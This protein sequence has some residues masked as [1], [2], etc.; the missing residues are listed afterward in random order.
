[1]FEA[2]V[3]TLIRSSVTNLTT[4]LSLFP[5]TC[6]TVRCCLYVSDRNECLPSLFLLMHTCPTQR[7]LESLQKAT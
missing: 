2:V 1:M 3:L 6:F 7:P 4:Y 5:S